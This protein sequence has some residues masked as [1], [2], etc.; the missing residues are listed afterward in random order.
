MCS[1]T[2]GHP[3]QFWRRGLGHFG[4]GRAHKVTTLTIQSKAEVLHTLGWNTAALRS[5]ICI[6]YSPVAGGPQGPESL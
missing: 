4:A 1:E 2:S 3:G 6:P 5:G